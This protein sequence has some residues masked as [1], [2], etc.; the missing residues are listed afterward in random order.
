MRPNRLG[1]LVLDSVTATVAR[2]RGP[3]RAL[4]RVALETRRALVAVSDPIVGY[5]LLGHDLRLR[6]SHELP[7]YRS[8]FP[9]YSDNLRRVAAAVYAKRPGTVAVDVGANI[10][11]SVAFLRTAG[12]E[13]IVAVEP[14]PEFASLLRENT[15]GLYGVVIEEVML[16]AAVGELNGELVTR[17]GTGRLV[18]GSATVPTT[19]VDIIVG[20]HV[21][22]GAV[23]LIKTDTDGLDL[24]IIR[25]AESTLAS[26]P[27]VFF[28]HDPKRFSLDATTCADFFAWLVEQGY[29]P[30]LVYDRF[31][32]L[33]AATNL[34]ESQT[35]EEL[36]HYARTTDTPYYYFDIAVFGRDDADVAEAIRARELAGAHNGAT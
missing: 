24:E 28:E 25:G 29:G 16:A 6:L 12:Y 17:E 18:R 31:G 11:D 34:A 15:R 22:L 26:H 19:T 32:T 2:R 5:D 3:A 35:V 9:G 36:D 14:A 10:G 7:L 21:D 13:R 30:T 20:A 27:A 1:Q 4:R 23:S 8:E 33:V